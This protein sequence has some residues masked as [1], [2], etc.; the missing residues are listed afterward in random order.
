[1]WASHLRDDGVLKAVWNRSPKQEYEDLTKPLE[2]VPRHADVLHIV[3]SDEQVASSMVERLTTNL[4]KSNLVIQSTTIDPSTSESLRENV[5]RTG[6]RYLEAPFTGSLPA[7]LERKTVFF[8]GGDEQCMRE[9][10]PYLKRLSSRWFHIGTARQ[11]ATIK[12][13]MNSQMAAQMIALAE[14]LLTSRR[15]AIPDEVFFAVL[16]ENM[17]YSGLARLKEPKLLAADYSPQFATEHMAKD[18]R[19]FCQSAPTPL[20]L[21]NKSAEILAKA[22]DAGF[23]KDDYSAVIEYLGRLATG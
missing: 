12:L 6:A 13:S 20:S 3:V 5:E 2:E 14:A 22:R 8:L 10:E 11:A 21:A 7:A 1:V 15:A 18:M 19:L 4:S 23:S 9:A 16:R 17:A